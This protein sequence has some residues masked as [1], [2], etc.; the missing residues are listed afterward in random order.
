MAPFI[1][2]KRTNVRNTDLTR[3]EKPSCSAV[4]REVVNFSAENQSQFSGNSEVIE[5]GSS[6]DEEQKSVLQFFMENDF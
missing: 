6:D 4:P 1:S 2:H 5:I 3:N